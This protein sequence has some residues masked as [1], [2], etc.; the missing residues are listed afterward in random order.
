MLK[1][2]NDVSTEIIRSALNP[3]AQE[4]GKVISNIVSVSFNWLEKKRIVQQHTL[5]K[6]IEDLDKGVENIPPENLI[7]PQ[8]HTIGPAIEASKF[9]MENEVLRGMFVNLILSSVDSTKLTDTHPSFTEIIK[10]LSPY[11]ATCLKE[12]TEKKAELGCCV[13]RTYYGSK[14][15]H[16]VK[17]I[18]DFENLLEQLDLTIMTV[19]NLIRLGLIE[20]YSTTTF[21]DKK[22]YETL[23]GFRLAE[24]LQSINKNK[25]LDT[26]VKFI[27]ARWKFTTLGTKFIKCCVV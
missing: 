6:L 7:S 15:Y 8:L 9:Y 20:C 16:D 11:D 17:Y 4:V 3:P 14:G 19:D 22:R 10:Q 1:Q 27:E 2:I 13:L 23:K 5:K 18:I 26:T 24:K 25:G 12:L 21:M